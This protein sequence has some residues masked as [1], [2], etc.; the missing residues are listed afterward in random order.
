MV[1]I[2]ELKRTLEPR[3]PAGALVLTDEEVTVLGGGKRAAVLVRVGERQAKLRL[4]VP[5]ENIERRVN[6]SRY[7][8][9]SGKGFM[10]WGSEGWAAGSA[11]GAW[12]G[13]ERQVDL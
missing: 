5:P 12:G 7:A 10:V 6:A 13:T 8:P 3:G 9:A 2:L 4:G 11:P 1:A